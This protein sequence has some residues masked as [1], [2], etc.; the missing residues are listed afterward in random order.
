MDLIND[1]P[2]T[3]LGNDS[4][5]V[6]VDRLSKM[7]H[8]KALTKT[9]AAP[10][11]ARVSVMRYSG[12]MDSVTVECLTETQALVRRVGPSYTNC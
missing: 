7:V 3:S 9:V 5:R 8:L 4:I 2:T 12:Y 11:L 6:C 1:M 10:E